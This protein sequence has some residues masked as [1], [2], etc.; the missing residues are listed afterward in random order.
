MG[1]KLNSN[2]NTPLSL[3]RKS[4]VLTDDLIL[5]SSAPPTDIVHGLSSAEASMRA[6]AVLI[7][8]VVEAALLWISLQSLC[9]TDYTA[10]TAG[11]Q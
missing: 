1:L 4:A 5:G 9:N 10:F 6:S 7:L 3:Q 2:S 8:T 11:Y